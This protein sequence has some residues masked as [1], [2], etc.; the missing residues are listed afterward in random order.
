MEIVDLWSGRKA[1]ALR[2]ALR[3]TNEAFAG[4][5]GAAVRTVAKWEAQPEIVLSPPMQEVLD[6]A[7]TQATDSARARFGLLI[8]ATE[9]V[10]QPAGVLGLP[11]VTASNGLVDQGET[12]MVAAHESAQDTVLRAAHSSD[13]LMTMRGMLI[14]TA[15]RYS[16][17]APISVFADA[18]RTRNLVYQVADR[19]RRPSE[20]AD[21]Y[22]VAGTANA[23]MASIAFDLGHWDA[24]R[25][26]A[27]SATAYADLAGHA[28]LEA[29]TWGLQ[30][31]LA[32]WRRDLSS[33]LNCF[34]RGL[35]V[36][37]KGAPRV[38]LRY[39]AART[40]TGLGNAGATA[41]FLDAAC[42]DREVAASTRDELQDEVRGEFEFND[43]RAAACAAAAW[44]ELREGDRAEEYAHMALDGYSKLP[45]ET[46][47][48][49]PVNGI[50]IDIA[51][52]RLIGRDLDGASDS[53]RPVLGLDAAQR[54]TALVG[55]L[56]SVRVTLGSPR[57]ARV[58]AARDL[59]EVIDQWTSDTA[60][61]PLPT[62]AEV[63]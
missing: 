50:R 56:K 38:R 10:D 25:S 45:E 52:A 4:H 24:A 33:A 30:A 31:T 28:S 12:F 36:A 40:H 48:F 20:L 21:L 9:H 61:V 23:L 34:E 55:R 22:V 62:E 54:N 2:A 35:A 16:Y 27:E 63:H 37:P 53:L 42:A 58:T 3:M 29:W 57:L 43:A 41:E 39:I 15:R 60:A 1:A 6:A 19:A 7:L 17:R 32:N 44:L 18:R 51:S 26:L 13:A 14:A 5:L 11:R 8:A 49:S 46:R 47:P 59:A